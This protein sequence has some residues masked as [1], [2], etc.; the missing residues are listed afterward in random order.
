MLTKPCVQFLHE[1]VH[2]ANVTKCSSLV[3]KKLFGHLTLWFGDVDALNDT[4]LSPNLTISLYTI[5]YYQQTSQNAPVLLEI[6][7]FFVIQ[8]FCFMMQMHLKY[9]CFVTKPCVQLL[10]DP[11]YSANVTKRSSLVR[12]SIVWSP[13][14]LVCGCRCTKRRCFVTNIACGLYTILAN[15]T[16]LTSLVR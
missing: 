6:T 15:L 16:K 13:N 10:H 8:C 3:R 12:K 14:C 1:P 2:S 5:L 11:V 9:H 4:V 7:G